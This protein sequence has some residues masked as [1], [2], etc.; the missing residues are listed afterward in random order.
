MTDLRHETALDRHRTDGPAGPSVHGVIQPPEWTE[1]ALCAQTDPEIF[2]PEK[3]GSN[4]MAKAICAECPVIQECLEYA[5][6]TAD[7]YG[8]YG[9]LGERERRKLLSQ[10]SR[11][12]AA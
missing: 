11:K 10:R 6:A 12:V 3:G 9:G 1:D 4:K 8:V 5:L 2:F 7:R